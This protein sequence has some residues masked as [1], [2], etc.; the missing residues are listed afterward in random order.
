MPKKKTEVDSDTGTKPGG[1]SP[2]ASAGAG[3][4]APEEQLKTADMGRA[5]SAGPGPA[6]PA[7]VGAD[8]A[9]V[10][11]LTPTDPTA[12]KPKR[13]RVRRTRAELDAERA[14]AEQA[15]AERAAAER[16]RRRREA[17]DTVRTLLKSTGIVW[18]FVLPPPLLPEEENALVFTGANYLASEGADIP[19]GKA[20]TV[21]VLA[22]VLPRVALGLY[23]VWKYFEAKSQQAEALAAQDER[24]SLPAAGI[25]DGDWPTA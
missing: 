15:T 16:E 14:A 8:K 23:R 1:T 5:G 17:G 10:I 25:P 24:A 18:E 22:I 20:L 4:G 12:T 2:G 13:Q 21:A 11:P 19:P 6:G 7:G 3:N 9:Q